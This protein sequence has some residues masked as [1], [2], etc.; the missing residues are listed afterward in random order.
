MKEQAL[1]AALWAALEEDLAALWDAPEGE[2]PDWSPD[3]AAWEA[4][5]LSP[6]PARR[7]RRWGRVVLA[8]AAAVAVLAGTVLAASPEVR[9]T[10]RQMF[11]RELVFNERVEADKTVYTDDEGNFLAETQVWDVGFSDGT[12]DH[13]AAVSWAEGGLD[14][15]MFSD[16]WDEMPLNT[17]ASAL[18]PEDYPD[19]GVWQLGRLPEGFTFSGADYHYNYSPGMMRSAHFQNWDSVQITG[20]SLRY[21]YQEAD[22]YGVISLSYSYFHSGNRFTMS[23]SADVVSVEKAEVNGMFAVLF[24]AGDR[25]LLS[26]LDREHNVEFSISGSLGEQEFTAD[27]LIQIAEQVLY[28]GP[29]G[30]MD[31]ERYLALQQDGTVLQPEPQPEDFGM[32]VVHGTWVW[33]PDGAIGGR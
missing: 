28:R 6:R 19:I 21:E 26:W 12:V 15:A 17:S 4:D 8:A 14:R 18:G 3:Y 7:K 30:P 20:G 2:M 13:Y 31:R 25:C 32:E 5:F 10:V 33:D 27:D 22:L 16:E 23:S 1:T 9:E 24:R 11:R 29:V